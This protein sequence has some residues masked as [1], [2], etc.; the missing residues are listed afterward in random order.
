M[1][2]MLAT[3]SCVPVRK[4]AV[5]W[6]V[7]ICEVGTPASGWGTKTGTIKHCWAIL[8]VPPLCR[9]YG[10]VLLIRPRKISERQTLIGDAG[11]GV[12]PPIIT[13]VPACGLRQGQVRRTVVKSP[14]GP[15]GHG[16]RVR[17]KRASGC[18]T[19]Q[20]MRRRAPGRL[21][22][23]VPWPP[24]QTAANFHRKKRARS[25]GCGGGHDW[26]QDPTSDGGVR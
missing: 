15:A 25:C 18:A 21:A 20:G 11:G 19:A 9:V 8:C 5:R 22:P 1:R 6:S 23:G 12:L 17:K 2:S 4:G 14:Q 24:C 16:G 10:P 26:M 13:P 7:P 3:C